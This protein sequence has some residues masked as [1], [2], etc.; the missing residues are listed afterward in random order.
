MEDASSVT[1]EDIPENQHTGTYA[2]SDENNPKIAALESSVSTH[3]PDL[4]ASSSHVVKSS[5]SAQFINITN[6]TLVHSVSA[7][8]SD[9]PVDQTAAVDRR[10][11]QSVAH[12]SAIATGT[13]L[14]I[15][16]PSCYPLVNNKC[17]EMAASSTR[18][19]EAF[20]VMESLVKEAPASREVLPTFPGVKTSKASEVQNAT[21]HPSLLHIKTLSNL[22]RHSPAVTSAQS[23]QFINITNKV[24]STNILQGTIFH[25]VNVAKSSERLASISGETLTPSDGENNARAEPK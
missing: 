11:P 6:K 8:C 2:T 9:V 7:H 13:N 12:L 3:N 14:S 24:K 19:N 15:V 10:K 21:C 20:L 4:S 25:P 22:L 18:A 1:V 17:T 5:P 16:Q 23:G